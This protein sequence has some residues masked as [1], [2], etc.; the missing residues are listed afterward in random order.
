MG[1]VRFDR[2]LSFARKVG[3]A[4]VVDTEAAALG[5][6]YAI[7]GACDGVG[8]T[9]AWGVSRIWSWS[10]EFAIVKTHLGTEQLA[11]HCALEVVNG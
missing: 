11:M 8:T 9:K 10:W 7:L 5:T 2:H 4:V 1:T 6:R 3:A